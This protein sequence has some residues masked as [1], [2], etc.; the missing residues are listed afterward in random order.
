MVLNDSVKGIILLGPAFNNK[1]M[2]S[3]NEMVHNSEMK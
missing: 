3:F 1:N 2:V